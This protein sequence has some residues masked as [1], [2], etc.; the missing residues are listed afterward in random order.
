MWRINQRVE[1]QLQQ[2]MYQLYKC[3]SQTNLLQL[4]YLKYPKLQLQ[5]Y[6]LADSAHL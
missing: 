5:L 3:L 6:S 4:S 2:M 1:L